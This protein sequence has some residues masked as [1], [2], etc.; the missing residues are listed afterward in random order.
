MQCTSPRACRPLDRKDAGDAA[1]DAADF[2]VD[3][4]DTDD[5]GE[6]ERRSGGRLRNMSSSTPLP[7]PEQP[8]TDVPTMGSTLQKGQGAQHSS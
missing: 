3:T 2:T 1:L 7:E 8:R 5:A 4:V 6:L